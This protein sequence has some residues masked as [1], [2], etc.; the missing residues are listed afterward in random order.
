MIKLV[1]RANK[2][3]DQEV[4]F[5]SRPHMYF[6]A[7]KCLW[8]ISLP[9]ILPFNDALSLYFDYNHLLQVN[10]FSLSNG[11][12]HYHQPELLQLVQTHHLLQRP[13]LHVLTIIVHMEHLH[14]LL[15]QLRQLSHSVWPTAIFLFDLMLELTLT[16]NVLRSVV[17]RVEHA[18]IFS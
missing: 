2:Y 15:K 18:S 1:F 8:Q 10:R 3:L 17:P 6:C 14:L 16:S 9:F 13:Q 4:L 11:L 5:C 12:Q 7:C